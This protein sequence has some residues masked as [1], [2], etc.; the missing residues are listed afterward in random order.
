MEMST[1]LKPQPDERL[2][3]LRNRFAVLLA[4]SRRHLSKVE[5]SQLVH[6]QGKGDLWLLTRP[7]VT[8]QQRQLARQLHWN[9]EELLKVLDE[10]DFP[11]S[12]FREACQRYR[13]V[14]G[15]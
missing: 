7:A 6:M 10:T 15:G 4:T 12:G 5:F 2:C 13:Q 1:D 8:A 14:F 3:R 9:L 11:R